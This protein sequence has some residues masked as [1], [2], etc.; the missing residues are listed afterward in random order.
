MMTNIDDDNNCNIR[1]EHV[2]R[3][4]RAAADQRV[5]PSLGRSVGAGR[6]S[7]T[8]LLGRCSTAAAA[9][10]ETSRVVGAR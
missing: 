5:A 7:S 2:F 6:G 1:L 8:Y 9:T 10:D 4:Q 3:H